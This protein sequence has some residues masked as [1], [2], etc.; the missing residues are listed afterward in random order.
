MGFQSREGSAHLVG[1]QAFE[2][3]LHAGITSSTRRRRRACSKHLSHH[4][5]ADGHQEAHELV[6]ALGSGCLL[7]SL[8]FT[9]GCLVLSIG[10]HVDEPQMV[11]LELRVALTQS[12]ALA[13]QAVKH[14]FSAAGENAMEGLSMSKLLPDNAR[15]VR[16]F[17]IAAHEVAHGRDAPHQD[18]VLS[19]GFLAILEGEDDVAFTTARDARRGVTFGNVPEFLG[20]RIEI[21]AFLESNGV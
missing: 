15:L 21:V 10:V 18:R 3:L 4:H 14:G 19:N 17:R 20:M 11:A 2:E 13:L 6:V 1:R 7:S 16:S 8:Q 12:V 5:R 9:F